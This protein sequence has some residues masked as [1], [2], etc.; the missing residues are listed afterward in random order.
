MKIHKF[1]TKVITRFQQPKVLVSLQA[2]KDMQEIISLAGVNEISW[3]GE[4][5]VLA[6]DQ[7]LIT[8]IYL[9]TQIVSHATCEIQEEGLSEI[10]VNATDPIKMNESL[11]FWGHLHPSCTAPSGQD[12]KQMDLFY[13]NDW[14]IRGIFNRQ[15]RAEM[16]FFDYKRGVVFEDVEWDILNNTKPSK[17][18]KLEIEKN[19]STPAYDYDGFG[20]KY[21]FHDYSY[22]NRE[23]EEA[24]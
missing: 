20:R 15:G 1:A 16:T 17:E 24:L 5:K 7:Y 19:V 9:P 6:N 11:R 4:V 10:L 18:W 21:H 8:K 12:E 22:R 13:S 23:R 2:Q 3:L 14:F